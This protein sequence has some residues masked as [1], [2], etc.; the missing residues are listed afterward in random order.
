MSTYRDLA[1]EA[2][3]LRQDLDDLTAAHTELIGDVENALQLGSVEE[4]LLT[5]S[6]LCR[7]ARKALPHG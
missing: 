3:T 7:T 4:V 5:I 2:A 1:D 6:D